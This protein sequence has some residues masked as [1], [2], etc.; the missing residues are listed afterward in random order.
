MPARQRHHLDHQC[1]DYDHFFR[2]QDHDY[3]NDYKSQHDHRHYQRDWRRLNHH[4]AS[5]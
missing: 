5:N 3:W 2:I 1:Q 4:C